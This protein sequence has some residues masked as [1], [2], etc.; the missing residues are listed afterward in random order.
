MRQLMESYQELRITGTTRD[1]LGIQHFIQRTISDFP[2]LWDIHRQ[3]GH[4]IPMS[5]TQQIA[6]QLVEIKSNLGEVARGV[7]SISVDAPNSAD[8]ARESAGHAKRAADIAERAESI[9]ATQYHDD[10]LRRLEVKSIQAA[11]R[12]QT[13][14]QRGPVRVVRSS[15]NTVPVDCFRN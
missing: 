10:Q 13:R 8:A 9:V 14:V 4:A 2:H 6:N 15:L 11:V 5:W 3:S 12:R 1:S 7:L